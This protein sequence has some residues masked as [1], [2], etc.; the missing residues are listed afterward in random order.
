MRPP[1]LPDNQKLLARCSIV[2]WTDVYA[3]YFDELPPG[4]PLDGCHQPLGHTLLYVG[5]APKETKG[6]SVEPSIR[7]LRHRM[8]DHF[9]ANAEGSTMRLTLGCLLSETLDIKLRRVG[10]G[11]RHTFTNPG[12]IILDTWMGRHAR[13]AWAVV[14]K[15]LLP[16]VPLPLNLMGNVHPFVSTLKAIRGAAKEAAER[17]P[18]V[19]DSGGSRRASN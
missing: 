3:W 11:K 10:R 6:Q 4:V 17:L 2:A 14:E 7:T 1:S 16:T 15:R 18:V 13:A 9:T 5:I 19:S 8:R 12:E